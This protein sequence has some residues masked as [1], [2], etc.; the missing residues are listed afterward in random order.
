MAQKFK[1]EEIISDFN[2]LNQFIKNKLDSIDKKYGK[3]VIPIKSEFGF[4]IGVII[5]QELLEGGNE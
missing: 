4:E 3:D 1:K 2:E 5:N